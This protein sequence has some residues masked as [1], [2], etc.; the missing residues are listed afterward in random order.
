MKPEILLARV[1]KTK[2]KMMLNILG[3]FELLDEKNAKLS[4]ERRILLIWCVPLFSR[5]H[6]T[7]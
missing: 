6:E 7:S 1:Q 3:L 2:K 5:P 4:S